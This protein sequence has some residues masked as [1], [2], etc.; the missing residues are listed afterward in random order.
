MTG[1]SMSWTWFRRFKILLAIALLLL[2]IQLFLGYTLFTLKSNGDNDG[3][4]TH[5]GSLYDQLLDERNAKQD[6]AIFNDLFAGAAASVDDEDFINSNA[7]HSYKDAVVLTKSASSAK[8]HSAAATRVP[9]I[10]GTESSSKQSAN[11]HSQ[12]EQINFKTKCDIVSKEAISAI[13]RA[14]TPECKQTLA[15]ISCDIQN[16]EFYPAELPNRCPHEPYQANR[17]LGCFSDDNKFRTLSGYYIN[18][19]NVNTPDRC[20]HLCLQSGFVYAGVEYS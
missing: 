8:E 13:L 18:L 20:I 19:K 12:T 10:I 9:G 17:S 6:K 16:D 11:V 1:I 7:I 14:K 15:N 4:S 3:D 5:S 2:S